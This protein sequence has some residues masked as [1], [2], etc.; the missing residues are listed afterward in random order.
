MD[1]YSRYIVAW[2]LS[3]KENSALS[4]QLIT[5]AHERYAIEPGAL[6][7]H[8]DRGATMTAHCYRDLLGELA[9]TASHRRPR[10][11][12]ATAFS[13]AQVKTMK[14]PPDYQRRFANYKHAIVWCEDHVSRY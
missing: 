5:Q 6:P 3:R 9:V 1:L 12:N 10:V 13:E 11:S 2:M 7:L 14:Y 4:S 8:Q